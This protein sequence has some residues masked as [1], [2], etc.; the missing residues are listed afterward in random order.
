M[1]TYP[2]QGIGKSDGSSV[3]RSHE[4]QSLVPDLK[5]AYLAELVAGFL[6]RDAVSDESAFGVVHQPVTGPM[7]DD[8][9]DRQVIGPEVLVG[10]LNVHDVHE[11][12]RKGRIRPHLAV[13]LDEAIAQN[14]PDLASRQR[15]PTSTAATRSPQEPEGR[16]ST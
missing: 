5:P 4:R 15:V 8:V 2:D 9:R 3:V 7:G 10:L 12:S 1:V 14:R 6:L 11:S 16:S 13:D